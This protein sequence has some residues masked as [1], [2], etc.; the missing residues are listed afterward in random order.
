MNRRLKKYAACVLISLLYPL[1]GNVSASDMTLTRNV[2]DISIY[3]GIIPSDSTNINVVLGETTK[4]GG[5]RG[6][7]HHVT[8]ALFDAK[9]SERITDA[10]VIARISQ[11]GMAENRKKLKQQKYGEAVSFGRDF[12]LSAK[13]TYWIDLSIKRNNSEYTTNT[14]FEWKHY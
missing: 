11:V 2:D 5:L 7:K 9:T 12:Y 4:F 14:R 3:M 10:K 1:I 8:V 13:G 6:K